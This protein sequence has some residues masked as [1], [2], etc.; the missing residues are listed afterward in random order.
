MK[1]VETD[2]FDSDY[3]NESFVNLPL[4]TEDHAEE[5]CNSI[6]NGFHVDFPRFWKVVPDDYRLFA[7]PSEVCEMCKWIKEANLHTRYAEFCM[8]G[9]GHTCKR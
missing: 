1:I 4:M 2:N 8:A 9:P 7:Q 5:V 6:N 3:P